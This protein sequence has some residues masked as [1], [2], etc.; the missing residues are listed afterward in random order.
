MEM[1]TRR[2]RRQLDPEQY[3]MFELH[4]LQGQP[5]KEVARKLGVTRAQV[6]FAR[7]K[8]SALLKREIKALKAA[9]S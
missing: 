6:Y 1:A 7:Y 3:Q 4:V 8:A 2:L 9:V 5:V